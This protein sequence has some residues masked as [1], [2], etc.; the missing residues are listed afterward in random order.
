LTHLWWQ[1]IYTNEGI[2]KIPNETA[3]GEGQLAIARGGM[4]IMMMKL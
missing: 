1:F 3:S 2:G 4:A